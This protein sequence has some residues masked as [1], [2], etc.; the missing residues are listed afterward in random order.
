MCPYPN[1]PARSFVL[2]DIIAA[3]LPPSLARLRRS[4]PGCSF[5]YLLLRRLYSTTTMFGRG[6]G[7]LDNANRWLNYNHAITDNCLPDSVGGHNEVNNQLTWLKKNLFG[8]WE[9]RR[10]EVCQSETSTTMTIELWRLEVKGALPSID[11]RRS[12]GPLIA[13]AHFENK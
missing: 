8:G 5:R 1:S 13:S 7:L 2:H 9:V 11:S 3:M 12:H 4:L 6:A 10:R